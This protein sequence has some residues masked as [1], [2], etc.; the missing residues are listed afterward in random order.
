MELERR[1]D[2]TCLTLDFSAVHNIDVTALQRQV[3]KRSQCKSTRSQQQGFTLIEIIVVVLIIGVIAS[4]AVLSIA[5]RAQDDRLENEVR[6]LTE[7]IRLG[8][9]EAI[10]LGIELGM[11]SD[12][13]S[14]EFVMIGEE[15]AWRGYETSGPLRPR[16]L[17]GGMK[18]EIVTEEFAAP[19]AEEAELIPNILFLSS[20]ELTPFKIRFSAEGATKVYQ[21]TGILTGKVEMATLGEDE[22]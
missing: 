13:E 11:R 18:L 3:G 6:R 17:P 1:V 2:L 19:A 22:I 16:K 8:S 20:G 4:F 10:L 5:D 14:Y 12:G 9:D 21:I 15:G 7:L